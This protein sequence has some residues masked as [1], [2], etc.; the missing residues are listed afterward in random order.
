MSDHATP[1]QVFESLLAG[2]TGHEFDR[3]WRLYADDCV[4]ELPYARP[5][6][7]RYEGLAALRE[8]FADPHTHGLDITAEDVRVHETGDPEVIVGEWIYRFA[9]DGRTVVTRNIQVMRVRAGAIVWSRDFH[10]HA[11]AAELLAA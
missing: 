7:I 4:V 8:H 11:A 2:I 6:P 9:V 3:L 10:D 5:E 1:R